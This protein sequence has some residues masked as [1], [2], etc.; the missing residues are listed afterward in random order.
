L[1]ILRVG[2]P[3]V[4]VSNLKE[5]E[6]LLSFV[7]QTARHHNVDR[8]ELLG[9]LLHSHAV[10]RLE[11]Q[12]FWT[13]WLNNLSSVCQTVVLVGNHDL[14]GDYKSKIS[15]LDVFDEMKNSNL[16]IVKSP[17]TLGK[18]GYLSY[19]HD[20]QEFITA[21]KALAESG[22]KILVCHQT[23]QGSRYESGFY[24]SDGIPTEGWGN[25]FLQIISGHIHAEQSFE[26]IFYPGT[27]RWD[28]VNDANQRKGIW[29]SEHDETGKVLY[30][31][32]V[33]TEKVCT[34]LQSIV[35]KEGEPE[36]V[37]PS[38]VRI[39]LELIG[40]SEWVA[41]E[42]IKFKGKASIKTKMTDTKKL[43]SR[44]IGKGLEDFLSNIYV[45]TVDRAAL[46]ACAKEHEIV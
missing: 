8:I 12:D 39:S 33:S 2:D 3:H 16:I 26:N 34:P 18:M 25:L 41:R 40:A 28:S 7:E 10:I 37:F 5:S 21:A 17:T 20:P 19:I 15:A 46:L 36:P 31:N 24:A 44:K 11:V 45:S 38:N 35:Y 9:D 42:K 32:F 13:K 14:S 22:A 1:K 27:A 23:L 29:I 6:A 43:E 30:H 4:K